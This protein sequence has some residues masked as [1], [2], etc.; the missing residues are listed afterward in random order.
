M[1]LPGFATIAAERP[2][3][4]GELT[5]IRETVE[6]AGPHP[7]LDPEVVA[8]I[9]RVPADTV[10]YV[11]RRLVALGDLREAER[12]VC[13]VC[14]AAVLPDHDGTCL[15]GQDLVERAPT[16]EPYFTFNGVTRRS[17]A[18]WDRVGDEATIGI[19]TA[20]PKEAAAVLKAFREVGSTTR[21]REVYDVGLAAGA[22][23]DHKIVHATSPMGNTAA[24]VIGTQMLGR[25]PT[26][27]ALIMVGIAGVVPQP[28]NP[29]KHA[30]LGDVVVSNQKGVVE[31]DF[32]KEEDGWEEIRSAP[33]RPAARLLWA[34][35][36]LRRYEEDG[37]PTQ[38]LP[39]I[40]PVVTI[41]DSLGVTVPREDSDVLHAAEAPFDVVE[42]PQDPS[43]S[44]G[45]PRIHL[46]PIASA[47]TL[48]KN[49]VRRDKLGSQFGVRAVEMEGAGIAEA[50][51]AGERGY[52]VI[53]GGCDYCDT[54]K[55]NDWQRYAAVVAAAYLQALL[56][57]LAV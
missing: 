5:A 15:C 42:H 18:F 2:N 49:P 4:Q 16:S 13:S 39:W 20:L 21:E 17:Q 41:A 56:R 3:L 54:F 30:R 55:N 37:T 51:W 6:A 48:L 47:G 32:K 28:A 24:G 7:V 50:A 11:F 8:G 10:R 43:R 1:C 9:T 27:D 35:G 26:V 25:F 12:L 44:P 38:A 46:A 23:G 14:E 22:D 33:T 45:L 29:E 19:I 57:H 53:R 36:R 34:V 52:L 40:T 31:Y